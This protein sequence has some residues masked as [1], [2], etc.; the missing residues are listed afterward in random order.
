MTRQPE[1]TEG[2]DEAWGDVGRAQIHRLQDYWQTKLKEELREFSYQ[3]L[4]T[5]QSR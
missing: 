2:L 5:D 1:A 4:T 3:P